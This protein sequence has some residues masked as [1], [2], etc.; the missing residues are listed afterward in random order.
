MKLKFLTSGESHG[1]ALIAILDG[2]PAGLDV[3]P[4]FIDHELARR[5]KGSVER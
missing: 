3:S 1:P 4:E 5:Q 2:I